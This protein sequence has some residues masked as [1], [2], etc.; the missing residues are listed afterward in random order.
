MNESLIKSIAACPA[1]KGSLEVGPQLTCAPCGLEFPVVDGIPILIDEANS[2][3]S[4]EDFKQGRPTTYGS[5]LKGWKRLVSKFI[6]SISLNLGSDQNY[7]NFFER[8][9]AK[10]S[11][12]RVLILGG[13][14]EGQGLDLEPIAD[15][16]EFVETDVSFGPR[17]GIICDAHDLPF[18]NESFDGVIAQAVLE[19]VLDPFRCVEE[20]ER[21]LVSNGLVYAETPFMQ[22][23]H[24]GRFDFL[25]FSHLG[26]RRL[27]RR[28]SEVSSGAIG[29][30]AMTLAWTYSYFLRGLFVNKT[31]QKAAFAFGNLTS[32]YLKY[33]DPLLKERPGTYDSA[34]AYYFMGTKDG[35]TIDDRELI[36]NYKGTF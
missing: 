7:K 8:L 33:L 13:A 18:K 20:M 2:I 11:R 30:P 24:M 32:F 23:V 36:M 10:R 9:R 1:C 17:T 15:Q 6:P 22:Q 34:S 27:F 26:H 19:H 35:K 29:G 4:I 16:F 12:P 31:L 5:P 3:F 14:I 25:R 21:V 28:F